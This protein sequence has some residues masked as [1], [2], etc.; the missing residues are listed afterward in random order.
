MTRKFQC[1]LLTKAACQGMRELIRPFAVQ[2]AVRSEGSTFCARLYA[3]FH[4]LESEPD[5]E[6]VD[7]AADE[8]DIMNI[9]NFVSAEDGDWSDDLLRQT[10]Q[11]LYELTTGHEAVQLAATAVM[12]KMLAVRVE[13]DT[14]GALVEADEEEAGE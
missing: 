8:L 12:E 13:S 2:E 9:N 6:A 1:L 5:L 10:R 4:S 11:V 14:D 3:A 7:F